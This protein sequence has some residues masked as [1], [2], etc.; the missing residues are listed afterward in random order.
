MTN[1][2]SPMTTELSAQVSGSC[3]TIMQPLSSQLANWSWELVAK[4]DMGAVCP[5][6]CLVMVT[7]EPCAGTLNI[8]MGP[9]D[10]PVVEWGRVGECECACIRT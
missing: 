3:H 8:N 9:S 4:S 10:V 2:A 1:L 6:S 7:S 5:S